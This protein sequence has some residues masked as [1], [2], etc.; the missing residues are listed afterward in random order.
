MPTY[1]HLFLARK[2]VTAITIRKWKLVA[3]T[4]STTPWRLDATSVFVD[5]HATSP[6]HS[7]SKWAK[8]KDSFRRTAS[9]CWCVCERDKEESSVGKE[10]EMKR[11][12]T[13]RCW[14]FVRRYDLDR[15]FPWCRVVRLCTVLVNIRE[16]II[17]EGG[18]LWLCFTYSYKAVLFIVDFWVTIK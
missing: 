13:A 15:L 4:T 9:S 1:T 16:L 2:L 17:D 18:S 10:W 3:C 12:E 14:L 5:K 8:N 6:V 7:C 11:L